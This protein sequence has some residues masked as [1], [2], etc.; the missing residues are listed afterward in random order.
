M[1]EISKQKANETDVPIILP[2]PIPYISQNMGLQMKKISGI[3]TC[4]SISNS[5]PYTVIGTS[6]GLLFI[7]FLIFFFL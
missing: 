6:R 1:F 7:L 3:P 4:L 5:S 2:T